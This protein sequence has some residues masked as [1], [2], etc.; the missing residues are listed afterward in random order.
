MR[1]SI[2]LFI[3]IRILREENAKCGQSVISV[4]LACTWSTGTCFPKQLSLSKLLD[5]FRDMQRQPRTSQVLLSEKHFVFW[6]KKIWN[7]AAEKNRALDNAYGFAPALWH[8]RGCMLQ[9]HSTFKVLEKNNLNKTKQKTQSNKKPNKQIKPGW[10]SLLWRGKAAGF[11]SGGG[12]R[13]QRL[14]KGVDKCLH[15]FINK[16]STQAK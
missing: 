5:F 14:R 8:W 4:W 13:S 16:R 1:E 12:R 2:L 11:K 15:K 10:D 9:I 3:N 6:S 7:G